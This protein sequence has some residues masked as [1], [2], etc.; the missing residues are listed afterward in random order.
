M[1]TKEE[2]GE[3]GEMKEKGGGGGGGGGE[4]RGGGKQEKNSKEEAE[5]RRRQQQEEE[6][7]HLH[8][9]TRTHAHIHTQRHTPAQIYTCCHH[10]LVVAKLSKGMQMLCFRAPSQF[11]FRA[12]A[13]ALGFEEQRW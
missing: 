6:E 5:E 1:R 2:R 13:R 9:H 4:G 12:P 10:F 3:K 11:F 7:T 8:A